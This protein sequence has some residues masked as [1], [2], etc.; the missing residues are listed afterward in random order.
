[1][2]ILMTRWIALIICPYFVPLLCAPIIC[3]YYLP[4]LCAH[5]IYPYYMPLLCAP[6]VY[7]LSC[8]PIMLRGLR[9]TNHH[10]L[11]GQKV[12]VCIVQEAYLWC[13]GEISVI[14]EPC[15]WDQSIRSRPING[16]LSSWPFY[17]T[18]RSAYI[19]NSYI[20]THWN[21]RILYTWLYIT[22][23]NSFNFNGIFGN[24]GLHWW[25]PV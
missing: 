20:Y 1:M 24:F 15:K 7:P 18:I 12:R 2:I 25:V 22:D 13:S 21:C 23:S 11:E 8:V 10:W 3:L 6:T 9:L 4:L 14:I 5:I 17:S 16:P 19:H